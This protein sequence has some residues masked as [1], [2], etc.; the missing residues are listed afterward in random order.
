LILS[1]TNSLSRAATEECRSI[2]RFPFGLPELLYFTLPYLLMEFDGGA[3]RGNV[4]TIMSFSESQFSSGAESEEHAH[5][6]RFSAIRSD[7]GHILRRHG[8]SPALKRKRAICWKD[9]IRQL[10]SLQFQAARLLRLVPDE[11]HRAT[12]VSANS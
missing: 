10:S 2:S 3:V 12:A 1:P 7:G 8:F 6:S 5:Q 11:A 4:F 9:F